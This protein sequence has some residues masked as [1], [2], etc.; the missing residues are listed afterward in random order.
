MHA[1]DGR[2]SR[3]EPTAVRAIHIDGSPRGG[4]CNAKSGSWSDRRAGD[5]DSVWRGSEECR[6]GNDWRRG[7]AGRRQCGRGN[8]RGSGNGSRASR[9]RS[10][11]RS[12]DGWRRQRLQIRSGQPDD[13]AGRRGEVGA[14]FR[15]SAQRVVLDGQHPRQC[16]HTAGRE[17]AQPD[18]AAHEPAVQQRERELHHLVRRRAGRHVQVLLHATPRDGYARNDHRAV[19]L[20]GVTRHGVACALLCLCVVAKAGTAHGQSGYYNLDSGR[21]V[22]AED[23]PP[24]PRYELELQVPTL[25]VERYDE[26]TFR[27]R[28][29]PKL[30][31]GV[32]PLTE[33]EVRLPVVRI[34]PRAP[35]QTV[36]GIASIGIGALHAF[37]IETQLVPAFAI[38]G[39][40]S[41]PVGS[42]AA[43]RT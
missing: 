30:S 43:P 10:D 8:G 19:S 1:T 9:Y 14:R 22:L 26:G 29:E 31:F 17:H 36:T 40:V 3:E 35:A 16:R 41:L 23:A 21:P 24:T 11:A 38:S 12:E 5:G 4:K 27:W 32:F 28:L 20:R 42:L 37:N 15:P 39:D 2:A 33:L 25:R 6:H 18:V 7:A 34:L 13:Q